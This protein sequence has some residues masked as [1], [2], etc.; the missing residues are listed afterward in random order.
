MRPRRRQYAMAACG[1]LGVARVWGETYCM[2]NCSKP[3]TNNFCKVTEDVCAYPTGDAEAY[4]AVRSISVWRGQKDDE[5][6]ELYR[7]FIC[8]LYFPKCRLRVTVPVCYASCL[9]AHIKCYQEPAAII[10]IGSVEP[11]AKRRCNA[12]ALSQQVAHPGCAAGW[13]SELNEA[14]TCFSSPA[15]RVTAAASRLF[16]LLSL[17]CAWIVLVLSVRS[18]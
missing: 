8:G 11:Q 13:N 6:I 5:C 16:W 4:K 15:T 7:K 1:L 9:A 18:A 2:S 10:H 12:L 14:C 17:A 3:T